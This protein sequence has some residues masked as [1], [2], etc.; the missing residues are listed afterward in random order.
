LVIS[1]PASGAIWQSEHLLQMLG[2]R[3]NFYFPRMDIVGHEH[4]LLTIFLTN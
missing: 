1:R 4:G 3:K 2:N